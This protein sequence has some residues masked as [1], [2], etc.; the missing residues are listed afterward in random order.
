MTE[1]TIALSDLKAAMQA[2]CC[3]PASEPALHALVAKHE[4][5]PESLFGRWATHPKVG[6]VVI[7]DRHSTIRGAVMI[8]L[9]RKDHATTIIVKLSE[10][11]LD[12]V[13]LTTWDDYM[14]AP[15]GTIIEDDEGDVHIKRD[16]TW[17]CTDGD[18]YSSRQMDETTSR[19][20]RWGDGK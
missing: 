15:I 6:R 13:T 18:Y 4:S 9:T 12:P 5:K 17:F 10:L 7:I 19:I 16:S 11:V 20:L 14:K 3:L 1:P 8:A 2:D